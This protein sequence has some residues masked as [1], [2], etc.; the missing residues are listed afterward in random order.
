[1]IKSKLFMKDGPHQENGE[2]TVKAAAS[3]F[4]TIQ[5]D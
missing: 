1:M 4:N 5:V 3:N 2:A